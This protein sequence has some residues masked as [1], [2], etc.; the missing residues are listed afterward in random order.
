MKLKNILL[1]ITL[2][3]LLAYAGVKGYIY[4]SVKTSLDSA[5]AQ[6]RPFADIQYGGIGS[7]LIDGAINLDSITITPTGATGDLRIEQFKIQGDGPRFL[8]D[9]S[10]GRVANTPPKKMLINLT[11]FTIPAGDALNNSLFSTDNS[12]S[13][14]T[15]CTLSGIFIQAGVDQLGYD[16]L[17]GD[18]SLGYDLDRSGGNMQLRFKYKMDGIDALDLDA[19]INGLPSSPELL[20]TSNPTLELLDLSYRVENGYMQQMLNHCADQHKLSRQE[21]IEYLL[22]SITPELGIQP[23]EDLLNGVRRM[24]ERPGEMQLHI[25]PPGE[26]N[27]ALL[28]HLP[29]EKLTQALGLEISFNGFPVDDLSF[30]PPPDGDQKSGVLGALR[31][32]QEKPDRASIDKQAEL[33]PK[34]P[35]VRLQSY[36][37]KSSVLDLHK[38]KG[39]EARI[40]S[41]DNEIPRRGVIIDVSPNYVTLEQH[42]HSGT[43][44][45]YIPK[46]NIQRVEV[47]LVKKMEQ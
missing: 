30:S 2:P 41:N 36:F 25:K 3:P 24:L 17:K 20:A 29:P 31:G 18:A 14:P 4:N 38:H 45:S 40:F 32:L 37:A 22:G 10:Q 1:L 5:I 6:A 35:K 46:E 23:S 43:F 9:L 47:Q 42:I 12:A 44:T 8:L 28:S 7:S 26:L 21:Y 11:G 27:P 15:A 16:Y 39:R 33:V 34:K 13:Q 19:V